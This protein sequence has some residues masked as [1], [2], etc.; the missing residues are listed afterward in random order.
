MC[1]KNSTIAVKMSLLYVPEPRNMDFW[2][3]FPIEKK[4]EQSFFLCS[5]YFFVFH[6]KILQNA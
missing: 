2:K 1:P 4:K 5:L 3:L 6:W